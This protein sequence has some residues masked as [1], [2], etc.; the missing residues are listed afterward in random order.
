[1]NPEGRFARRMATVAYYV[2][3][4][5]TFRRLRSHRSDRLCHINILYNVTPNSR[6]CLIREMSRNFAQSVKWRQLIM[7]YCSHLESSPLKLLYV[8]E[9]V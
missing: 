4:L 3:L 8:V 2:L 9:E 5:L 6:N 1:M 7:N